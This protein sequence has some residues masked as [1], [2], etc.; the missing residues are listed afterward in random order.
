[1]RGFPCLRVCDRRACE[2]AIVACEGASVRVRECLCACGR[3][4]VRECV[5]TCVRARVRFIKK[6][7]FRLLLNN[8]N[9]ELR[10]CISWQQKITERANAARAAKYKHAGVFSY[11]QGAISYLLRYKYKRTHAHA[12]RHA[13]ARTHACLYYT[14][15]NAKDTRRARAQRF[16]KT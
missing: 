10:L 9:S 3:A 4:C 16:T 15:T 1:M 6:V 14:Y 5:R 7:L 8:R 12:H 2:C 13:H 11:T